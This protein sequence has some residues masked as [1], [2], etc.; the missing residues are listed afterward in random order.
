MWSAKLF[1][2]RAVLRSVS[3]TDRSPDACHLVR[4]AFEVQPCA[5]C[6]QGD[7]DDNGTSRVLINLRVTYEYDVFDL[8]RVYVFSILIC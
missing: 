7:G 4:R 2:G 6:P 8:K 5:D 1:I 3:G